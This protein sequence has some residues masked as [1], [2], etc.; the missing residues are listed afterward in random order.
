MAFQIMSSMSTIQH[1]VLHFKTFHSTTY[2][3]FCTPFN[4]AFLF[5]GSSTIILPL[6]KRRVITNSI[7]MG[8]KSIRVCNFHGNYFTELGTANLTKG[9]DTKFPRDR[10]TN[11]TQSCNLGYNHLFQNPT[12]DFFFQIQGTVYSNNP[13]KNTHSIKGYIFITKG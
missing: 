11:S 12:Q 1:V 9:R 7:F 6:F 13:T 8:W 2:V 10:P 3:Q 4:P 5:I